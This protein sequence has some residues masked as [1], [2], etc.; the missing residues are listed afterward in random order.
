M[1]DWESFG[2][3]V[4]INRKQLGLTQ[5][6]FAKMVFCAA[7]TLRKIEGDRLRPS[8][9][10]AYS[11]VEKAGVPLEEREAFVRWARA[12][13]EPLFAQVMGNFAGMFAA[14]K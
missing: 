6:E 2:R 10:L 8:R 9:E 12:R 7:I 3:W 14:S 11:I 5:D 1:N 13:R 4:K